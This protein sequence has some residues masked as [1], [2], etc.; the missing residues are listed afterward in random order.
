MKA[1]YSVEELISPDDSGG[2]KTEYAIADNKTEE[3]LVLSGGRLAIYATKEEAEKALEEIN[4][5]KY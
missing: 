5:G 3:T 4:Y 1:R 2:I